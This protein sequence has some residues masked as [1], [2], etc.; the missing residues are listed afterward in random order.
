MECYGLSLHLGNQ[1]ITE[2]LLY[3]ETSSGFCVFCLTDP[4]RTWALRNC[5]FIL[6]MACRSG[7]WEGLS[8]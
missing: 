6:I 1:F 4:S 8:W 5:R 3:Y 2:T 7:I